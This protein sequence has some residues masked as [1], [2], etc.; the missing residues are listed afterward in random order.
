MHA[1]LGESVAGVTTVSMDAGRS[2]AAAADGGKPKAVYPPSLEQLFL[3][4]LLTEV[5]YAAA[6]L[7]V[8]CLKGW[9]SPRPSTG[10]EPSR[11]STTHRTMLVLRGSAPAAVRVSVCLPLPHP[12]LP[13]V[14]V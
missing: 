7:Q 10:M 3:P 6:I 12:M 8:P 2:Q 1:M 13:F 14:G 4:P 5:P 11:P 9:S